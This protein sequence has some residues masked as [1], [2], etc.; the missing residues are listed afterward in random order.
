MTVLVCKTGLKINQ[1]RVEEQ[2][3]QPALLPPLPDLRKFF[4]GHTGLGGKCIRGML[5]LAL[6][7]GSSRSHSPLPTPS[8]CAQAGK[9][10]PATDPLND[11]G[12]GSRRCNK[13]RLLFLLSLVLLWGHPHQHS[14][15]LTTPVAVLRKLCGVGSDMQSMCS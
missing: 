3:S 9:I 10:P 6:T 15:L 4:L 1:A 12:N 13:P 2:V 5:V 7:L 11:S 8:S 14:R